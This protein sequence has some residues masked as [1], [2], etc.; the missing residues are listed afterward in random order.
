MLSLS[1][2]CELSHIIIRVKKKHYPLYPN[3]L[4]ALSAL[5]KLIK[6][7]IRS[8]ASKH[9]PFYPNP[10]KSKSA[11]SA[12]SL[13]TLSEATKNTY[14]T[15]SE[16]PKMH[17][18]LYPQQAKAIRTKWEHYPHYPNEIKSLSVLSEATKN[19]YPNQCEHYPHYPNQQKALSTFSDSL[20]S[21]MFVIRS[22]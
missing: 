3:P 6:C 11:L 4:K 2:L 21:N 7:I 9:H 1:K 19:H 17:Y 18:P 16:P 14:L 12:K 10:T 22:R 5:S 8:K 20:K 13:S 15:L